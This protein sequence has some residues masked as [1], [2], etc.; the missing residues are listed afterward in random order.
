MSVNQTDIMTQ[1]S[2]LLGEQT[3]PTS[4]VAD[5]QSFIQ[6][7]V[8]E[9]YR[10]YPWPQAMAN[11]T[12]TVTNYTATLA[13]NY[14][15]QGYLDVREVTSGAQ[16]DDVY[17]QIPYEEHDDYEEGQYRYWLTG[18]DPNYVINTKEDASAL[19]VRYMTKPPTVNASITVPFD[20]PM[21]FALGALRYVRIGE[22]PEADITQEE[23]NFQ[24]K[25]DQLIG[26]NNRG[27]PRKRI[28]TLASKDG[29]RTGN[30]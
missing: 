1:L 29:W 22:N 21:L 11:A 7:T 27:K 26:V 23:D 14:Y 5:R 28:Q 18:G 12:L 3:V 15:P 30:V 24:L 20:D 13:S 8:E 19:S 6:R 9:V 10:A 16:D 17:D 25:L 4:N 2:Y